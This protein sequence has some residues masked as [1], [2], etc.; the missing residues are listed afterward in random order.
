VPGG[1]DNVGGFNQIQATNIAPFADLRRNCYALYGQDDWRVTPK[2]TLNLGL[3]W[4]YFG[5][6]TEHFDAM[7]NFIPGPNFQGGTFLS[8]AT[9]KK[10]VPQAF[11]DQLAKDGI[12]FAPTSGPPW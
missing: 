11:I 2:L 1:I 8:P 5:R 9:R 10:E 12:T 4:E 3:R 7:S 6:P